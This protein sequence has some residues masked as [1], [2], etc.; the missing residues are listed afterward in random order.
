MYNLVTE[1]FRYLPISRFVFPY[2][3]RSHSSY[4]VKN[5]QR[6]IFLSIVHMGTIVQDIWS[7][8]TLCGHSQFPSS[9]SVIWLFT[10]VLIVLRLDNLF[11]GSLTF[12]LLFPLLFLCTGNTNFCWR[13]P[14]RNLQAWLYWSIICIL[15]WK[16]AR[17]IC[18]PT[19]SRMEEIFW[20]WS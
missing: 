20:S 15:S 3:S 6:S 17:S 4:L 13:T 2:F 5:T 10:I 7:F 14:S 12:S 9:R 19:N 18:L 16:K 1:V 8:I 11:T